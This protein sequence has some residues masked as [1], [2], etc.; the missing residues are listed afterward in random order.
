[1]K[2]LLYKFFSLKEKNTTI[3]REIIGGLI[4]FIAMCYILPVN[5]GIL[6]DMGMN[7]AGVFAMTAFVSCFVT[8]IMGLVANYPVV[9]SAGMGLNAFIT[10]SVAGGMGF[11]WQQ[12]MILLTI[13][14]IVF[15]VFSLTPVRKMIIEAIPKDIQFIISA[16]LGAF[17]CLVGLK[18]SGII[19]AD[20]GTLIALGSFTNPGVIIAIVCTIICFGLMMTKNKMLSNLAIPVSIILAAAAGIIV[21]TIMGDAV[22]ADMNLPSF[23][24]NW[25]LSGVEDVFLYGA[26]SE[27]GYSDF[28]KDIVTVLTTPASYI[29][30]FSLCFVNLFDTTATLLTVGH[31]AGMIGEDGKLN[32]YRKAVLADS[33]GALICA[34]LGTSTVTSFVESNVGIECGSR[35]G[36]SAVISGLLFL[37]SAFI[38]PVFSIFTAGCV[39]APALIAVGGLIFAGNIKQVD[40]KNPIL[41]FTA[42]ITVVFAILTY[43]ISNAIG[44]GLIFYCVMMLI[45]GKGKE[46]QKTIYVVAGVFVIS[47][48]LTAILE[49]L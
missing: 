11:S 24:G 41:G 15:F 14:G 18:G 36:L 31:N 44:F 7:Q 23:G 33:T 30:I 2:N 19:V 21:S 28:G 4:T 20:P 40:L 1:M 35:T 13:S 48:V 22:T 46:V 16:A 27:G 6:S 32:N 3:K 34:P 5:A 26:F 49:L 43:S 12:S 39:T 10:Y 42:F 9:L 47:F 17:I 38:F 37:V 25:G 8:L 29:A 45:A